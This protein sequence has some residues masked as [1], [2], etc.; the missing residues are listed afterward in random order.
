MS[1]LY[2][3]M[4]QTGT[5][6]SKVIKIY[7]GEEYNHISISLKNKL[8]PMYSF[9]RVKASNP[10]SSGFV[11]ENI[12]EGVYR[13]FRECR[14]R[15]Y[16]LEVSKEQYIKLKRT[17]KEF[18]SNKDKYRYNLLGLFYIAFKVDRYR[19]NHYFCSQFVAEV[20]QKSGI[21]DFS[22][23]LNLVTVRDFLGIPNIHP[24]FEGYTSRGLQSE[25]V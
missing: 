12:N 24:I 3:V 11:L 10:F 22:K 25:A 21:Y 23:P 16:K 5:W 9:G 8:N 15:V 13:L 7:T 19:K 6:L 14:C 4:S 20:I 2:L 18:E 1:T 17:L